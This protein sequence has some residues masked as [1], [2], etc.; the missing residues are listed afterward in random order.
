MRGSRTDLQRSTLP[1][2]YARVEEPSSQEETTSASEEEDEAEL[3]DQVR[4][5]MPPPP[6]AYPPVNRPQSSLSSKRYRTPMASMLMSPPPASLSV[7]P[8]QPMPRHETP[9]A[10]ADVGRA[11][12]STYPT[13]SVSYPADVSQSSRTDVIQSPE[14]Y[15]T[16]SPYRP[17]S[18]QPQYTGRPYPLQPNVVPRPVLERAVE[19]VQTHL[20]ALTERIESLEN[21][22]HRSTSSLAS[23]GGSRSPRWMSANRGASPLGRVYEHFTYDDMGMWSLVLNPLSVVAWRFRR[24]MEFLMYNEN[25]S[26]TLV[27][28]RRLMLD[29]SFLLCVLAVMRFGWRRSGVRRREVLG[30]LK[31][32]WYALAGKKAPR[33]L[34]DRAV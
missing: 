1:A 28:V 14:L 10:Y 26:P 11:S 7:P 31:G 16:Q 21:M 29:I 30:A 27:V 34:V 19:N 25:R 3:A 23:Q 8:S 9:S 20:A 4:Q 15:R 33:V 6:P 2:S 12:P 5:P 32:L 24:L 22:A 13:T 17:P 18:Q